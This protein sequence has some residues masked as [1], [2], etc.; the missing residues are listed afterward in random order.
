MDQQ[1]TE[2]AGEVE[3]ASWHAVAM[4]QRDTY[5]PGSYTRHKYGAVLNRPG[6]YYRCSA[7]GHHSDTPF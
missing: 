2:N 1:T 7:C 3:F 4:S 6:Y 5:C